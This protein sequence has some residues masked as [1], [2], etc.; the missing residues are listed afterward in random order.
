MQLQDLADE[1]EPEA[2]AS[3]R[4]GVGIAPAEEP[5]AKVL[6]LL[7][8]HPGAVVADAHQRRH[9]GVSHRHQNA[10]ALRRVLHRIGQEILEHAL[11]QH[12]VRFDDQRGVRVHPKMVPG[13]ERVEALHHG[14]DEVGH[15]DVLSLDVQAAR[16]QPREIQQPRDDGVQALGIRVQTRQQ[17][18]PH[19]FAQAIPLLLERESHPRHDSERRAQ[20]V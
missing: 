9:A 16:F 8:R 7:G 12:A 19:L 20:L 13:E 10:A 14:E 3:G 1:G 5:F 2:R 18:V 17:L 11:Q 15:G 6:N 4:P